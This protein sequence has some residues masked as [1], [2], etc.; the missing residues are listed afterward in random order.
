MTNEK[1]IE[2]LYGVAVRLADHNPDVVDKVINDY[3]KGIKSAITLDYIALA[4]I[5]ADLRREVRT[6]NLKQNGN[7][8]IGKAMMTLIKDATKTSRREY[9]HGAW[10]VNGKQ[11]ATN[12]YCGF[13]LN[14]PIDSL[15]KIPD[16]CKP[17]NLESVFSSS[18]AVFDSRDNMIDTPS[19]SDLKDFIV[20]EKAKNS[21][22]DRK[23]DI[24][25]HP[26]NDKFSVNAD[27][28]LNVL[29]AFPNAEIHVGNFMLCL[30]DEAGDAI[31]MG[32]RIS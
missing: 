4:Y 22:R 1:M 15:P 28:L 3:D 29:I 18:E 10:I 19:I 27:Y 20:T 30:H 5:V 16:D 7:A 21:F 2:T 24:I 11:Y 26:I 31:I 12:S 13:R 32:V 14:N 17:F 8:N 6:K 25:K 23:H 9:L